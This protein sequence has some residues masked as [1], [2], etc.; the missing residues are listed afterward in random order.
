M[1]TKQEVDSLQPRRGPSSDHA[2]LRLLASKTVRNRC[3]FFISYLVCGILLQQPKRTKTLASL[4]SHFCKTSVPFLHSPLCKTPTKSCLLSL[5]PLFPSY[6]LLHPL[7]AG[8]DP[9]TPLKLFFS[10][11]HMTSILSYAIVN[12]SP[13]NTCNLPYLN[14][15]QFQSSSC[16]AQKILESFLTPLSFLYL[17]HQ[18]ILWALLAKY[19]HQLTIHLHLHYCTPV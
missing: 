19:I 10:Q 8:F 5:S 12:L 9:T 3:L 4:T 18:Q 1:R 6:S 14:R 17:V 11:S 13:Y 15:C 16:S 2:D 7:Q